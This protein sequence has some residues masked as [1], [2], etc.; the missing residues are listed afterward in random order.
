MKG[1]CVCGKVVF[2]VEILNTDVHVCHCAMCRKQSSGILMSIDI[3]PETLQFKA[4]Q[5]LSIYDSS[6]WGE[7]G[8]CNHC[9]TSLFWR[10]KNNE[11]ANVNA[12][13]VDLPEHNLH[14]DSEIFIDYKPKF[15]E[16]RNLTKKL[17]EAEV[18]ALVTESQ[19]NSQ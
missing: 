7:R 6:E 14:L 4:Q 15:Y 1:Q 18:M 17:T 5:F 16:F 13:A 19:K 12:F 10:L 3:V 9:G 2:D 11:Y 8:F